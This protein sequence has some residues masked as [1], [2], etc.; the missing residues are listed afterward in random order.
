M[1]A[2]GGHFY[3][4]AFRVRDESAFSAEVAER[5]MA[6][7]MEIYSGGHDENRVFCITSLGDEPRTQLKVM[8]PAVLGLIKDTDNP[9]ELPSD[10]AGWVALF[11]KHLHPDYGIVVMQFFDDGQQ[12]QAYITSD[13]FGTTN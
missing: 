4:T 3:S 10:D 6:R 5:G 9:E 11:Q 8:R 1:F 12:R 13:A 2:F 7:S